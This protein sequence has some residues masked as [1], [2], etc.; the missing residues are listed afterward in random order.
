[1]PPKEHDS[2]YH[3][4]ARG[5]ARVDDR[6]LSLPIGQSDRAYRRG[7][8]GRL[9]RHGRD[10]TQRASSGDTTGSHLGGPEISPERPGSSPIQVAA[11]SAKPRIVR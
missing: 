5:V 3:V 1:M 2:R 4:S 7:V 11:D 10:P 6:R 9:R 8:R